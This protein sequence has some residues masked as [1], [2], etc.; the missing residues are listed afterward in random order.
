ALL[1]FDQ[2]EIRR[3]AG[4]YSDLYRLELTTGRL[5]RL[6]KDARLMDPDFCP[7]TQTIVAVRNAPD[8]R[9]LVRMTA[10][11]EHGKVGDFMTIVSEPDTQF[12]A[13]RLTR[14]ARMI[15][16]ERHRR[17]APSEIVLVDA[18]AGAIR[19]L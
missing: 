16:A 5:L 19:V 18:T 15:V 10:D 1:Y 7:L 6:T 9:E 12:N 3:N 8:R 4:V 11:P 17:G 2:Q 14:D 13:P